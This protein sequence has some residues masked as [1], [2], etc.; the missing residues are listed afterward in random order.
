MSPYQPDSWVGTLDGMTNAE[1]DSLVVSLQL[2]SDGPP[3]DGLRNSGTAAGKLSKL[4][5]TKKTS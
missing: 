5:K 3:S 1:I 4:S 2:H